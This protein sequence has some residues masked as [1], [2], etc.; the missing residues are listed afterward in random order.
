M[1][2][3]YI[4]QQ[5]GG[6]IQYDAEK[7]SIPAFF[8]HCSAHHTGFVL[9]TGHIENYCFLCAFGIYALHKSTRNC[10]HSSAN[11]SLLMSDTLRACIDTLCACQQHQFETHLGSFRIHWQVLSTCSWPPFAFYLMQLAIEIPVDLYSKTK[12]A[13]SKQKSQQHRP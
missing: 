9:W 10:T 7:C 6:V 12:P 13:W 11:K 2:K 1:H 4:A 3:Q 8:T 5:Y